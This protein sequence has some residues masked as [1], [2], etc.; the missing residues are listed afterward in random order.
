MILVVSR[1]KVCKNCDKFGALKLRANCVF[2]LVLGLL[3]YKFKEIGENMTTE[4][5]RDMECIE[6][7]HVRLVI[8]IATLKR[9]ERKLG[10]AN[11][12]NRLQDGIMFS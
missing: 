2:S 11:L 3:I 9:K 1:L 4:I 5:N 12:Q 7:R 10:K 6:K 8:E